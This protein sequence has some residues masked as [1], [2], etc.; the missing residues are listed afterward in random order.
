MCVY[1]LR[2]VCIGNL[3]SSAAYLHLPAHWP[4]R[5][6]AHG[7]P[8]CRNQTQAPK[9]SRGRGPLFACIWGAEDGD[10]GAARENG[11]TCQE[12]GRWLRTDVSSAGGSLGFAAC[13]PLVSLLTG[14]K[15]SF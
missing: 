2:H 12:Q 13:L 5:N 11:W 4:H 9:Q 10:G 3:R 14:L 8:V 1:V 15:P 6:G 7:G